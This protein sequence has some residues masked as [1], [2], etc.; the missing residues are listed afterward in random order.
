MRVTIKYEGAE[1]LVIRVTLPEKQLREMT[2]L[3]LLELFAKQ[4]GRKFNTEG[5]SCGFAVDEHFLKIVGGKQLERESLVAD[6]LTSDAEVL[7]MPAASTSSPSTTAA[8]GG[9]A[10]P[11]RSEETMTSDT[12]P[13]SGSPATTRRAATSNFQPKTAGAEGSS[14]STAGAAAAGSS[15]TIS[16]APSTSST[17]T[18]CP[19]AGS[20]MAK[21]KA[22]ESAGKLR[23]KNFGCNKFF[24]PETESGLH[25]CR[26]H[27]APPIFHETAKWWSCCPNHKAYD[28]DEFQNVYE[29]ASSVYHEA[30]LFLSSWIEVG[31]GAGC[32]C[33]GGR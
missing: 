3:K 11:L 23:C 21:R 32:P 17:A 13:S 4:H 12:S 8:T 7:V 27:K 25:E 2:G 6:F 20:L 29:E 18:T 31:R 30:I 1:P 22:A 10:A 19:E 33:W 9:A 28:W 26:H 5:R 24:D 16:K 15:T 14:S